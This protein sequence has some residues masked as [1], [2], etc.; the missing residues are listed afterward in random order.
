MTNIA[1]YLAGTNPRGSDTDS[2]GLLDG[3]EVKYS[4]NPLDNTD[5]E[6]DFDQD[7]LTNAQEITLKTDLNNP[8]TDHDN[9]YDGHEVLAGRNPLLNEPVLIVITTGLI[10]N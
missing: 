3:V 8:D 9:M 6:M 7:G 5:A 1:E 2:D 10:L 4:L